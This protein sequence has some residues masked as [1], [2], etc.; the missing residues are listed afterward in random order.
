MPILEKISRL[1]NHCFIFVAGTFMVAMILITC[2][3]IFSRL[4]WVPV[5]GTFELMGFFGAVVTAFALG[6]TQA[7]KA[8][9]SVDILVNRFPKRVQKI[10][11]GINSVICLIFFALAGWQIAKLGNTLRTSGEVTETLRIIYYPFTYGVALGCFLL[12]LVLLVELVALFFSEN[13][14][15]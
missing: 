5:K 6:Y 15:T 12:S 4:V 11:S 10:L 7:K 8:H 9:I 3:N 13:G 14:A 2:L 1:M